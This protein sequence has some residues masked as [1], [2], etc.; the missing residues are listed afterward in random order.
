MLELEIKKGVQED[1]GASF[2]CLVTNVETA[3]LRMSSTYNANEME[4]FNKMVDDDLRVFILLIGVWLPTSQEKE[5]IR[6]NKQRYH[7]SSEGRSETAISNIGF[8]SLSLYAS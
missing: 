5:T 3:I 4:L 2:Y 6:G 1:D 7:L 8:S